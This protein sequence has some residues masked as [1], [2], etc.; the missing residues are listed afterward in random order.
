MVTAEPGALMGMRRVHLD[1]H[2]VILLLDVDAAVGIALEWGV[3]LH[4]CVVCRRLCG[5]MGAAVS[6]WGLGPGFVLSQEYVDRW[7]ISLIALIYL[8]TVVREKICFFALQLR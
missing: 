3:D 8:S 1:V 6:F 5:R 4:H 7:L 2:W